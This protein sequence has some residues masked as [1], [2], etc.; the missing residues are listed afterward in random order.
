MAAERHIE[1]RM[2]TRVSPL[3]PVT[4]GITTGPW[5]VEQTLGDWSVAWVVNALWQGR[6]AI[7]ITAGISP[8]SDW[9]NRYR[10]SVRANHQACERTKHVIADGPLRAR[11]QN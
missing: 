2:R 1:P 6:M 10:I 7:D 9:S 4:A 8:V 3:G 5:R 11:Y